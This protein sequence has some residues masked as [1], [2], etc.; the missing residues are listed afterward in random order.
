MLKALSSIRGKM[1]LVLLGVAIL[2]SLSGGVGILSL[3]KIAQS[4]QG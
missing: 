3:R 2:S 4:M 1:I